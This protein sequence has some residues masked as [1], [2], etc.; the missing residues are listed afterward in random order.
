ML[1]VLAHLLDPHLTAL[2]RLSELAEAIMM[3]LDFI[4][5]K[6]VFEFDKIVDK[7]TVK[8]VRALWKWKRMLFF[9]CFFL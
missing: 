8:D 5:N 4:K 6:R 1:V 3:V 7:I 2:S 9:E